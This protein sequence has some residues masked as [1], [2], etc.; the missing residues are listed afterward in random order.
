MP[1]TVSGYEIVTALVG[2]FE[3]ATVLCPGGKKVVGGGFDS[4]DMYLSPYGNSRTS[5]PDA[6]RRRMDC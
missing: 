6:N 5:S 2:P 3:G 1:G 4:D